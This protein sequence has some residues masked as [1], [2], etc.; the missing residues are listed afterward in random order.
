M[1]NFVRTMRLK[2]ATQEG[3]VYTI[4]GASSST[5]GMLKE[6][7][8]QE[9]KAVGGPN[10]L[11][12]PSCYFLALGGRRILDNCALGKLHLSKDNSILLITTDK[13][14]LNESRNLSRRDAEGRSYYITVKT[15]KG[16]C[17]G[18]FKPSDTSETIKARLI[19]QTNWNAP[20]CINYPSCYHLVVP[21]TKEILMPNRSLWEYKFPEK[22]NLI[23]LT[24]RRLW[25]QK[26][27]LQTQQRRIK[28][29]ISSKGTKLMLEAFSDSNDLVLKED[30]KLWAWGVM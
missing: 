20:N 14:R 23:I 2:L 13:N 30:Q 22:Q 15:T 11:Q 5:V 3:D 8:R 1:P 26:R 16:S 21:Q 10:F 9:V 18:L 7:L 25:E 27:E 6:T 29:V 24:T 17:V 12:F 19:S 4:Q 28:R